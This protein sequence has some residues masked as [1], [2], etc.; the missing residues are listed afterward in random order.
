MS[1]K[2]RINTYSQKLRDLRED[3]D[4]SQKEVANILQVAQT[5]YSDYEHG[6]VRIPVEC[7]I[8][9]AA[10]YDVDLNYIAGISSVK[11]NFPKK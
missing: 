1:Y 2:S 4:L 5:T 9:L 3:N 11:R 7:L 10:Y 8:E 6:Y